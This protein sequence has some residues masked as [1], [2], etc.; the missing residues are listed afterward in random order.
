V[1]DDLARRDALSRLL[2]RYLAPLRLHLTRAR[3][4]PPDRA[5]D[6]LQSFIAD[7]LLES[8][9]LTHAQQSRGRFRTFLLTSLNNF[10]VSQHRRD[11]TQKRGSGAVTSFDA[12]P[13]TPSTT[14]APDA[15]FDAAWARELLH[16]VL[17]RMETSCADRPDLWLVFQS[18][19][20]PEML[21]EPLIPYEQLIATLN[22]PTPAHAANLLTTAKRLYARLLRETVG[23]YEPSLTSVEEELADLRAALS[24]G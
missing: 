16:T 6:L 22:L 13:D 15:A 14:P 17:G 23:E 11:T 1:A 2:T 3:R 21:D 19:V 18:R 8:Q 4:L 10:L 20:L 5:D 9:L 24:K 12:S 7:K